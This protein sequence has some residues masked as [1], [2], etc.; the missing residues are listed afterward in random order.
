MGKH[1]VLYV[2]PD[3]V[4]ACACGETW[5]VV[6]AVYGLAH[7]VFHALFAVHTGE[8]LCLVLTPSSVDHEW[9]V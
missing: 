9:L 6:Y 5:S 1:L 2:V 3:I 4:R 8:G 7:A